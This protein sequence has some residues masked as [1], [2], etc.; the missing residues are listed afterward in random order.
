MKVL[1]PLLVGQLARRAPSIATS[2][3]A[4]KKSLS[5]VSETCLLLIVYVAFCD[6]FA[7]GNAGLPPA[8]LARIVGAVG[9]LHAAAL[10]AAWCAERTRRHL[11]HAELTPTMLRAS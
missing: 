8:T 6:A 7:R 3:T 5:R 11:L 2:A 1:A 4:R 9:T 10:A